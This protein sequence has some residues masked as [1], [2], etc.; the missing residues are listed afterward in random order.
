MATPTSSLKLSDAT[1][2]VLV[3]VIKAGNYAVTACNLAGIPEQTFYAWLQQADKDELVGATSQESLYIR[4]KESIKNAEADA[5]VSLVDMVTGVA[6]KD[7]NWI[8][9]MTLLERRHPDRWGR[10]DR[11]RIDINETKTVTIT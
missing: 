1:I 6:L 5:E 8:A 2:N 7:R 11:T 4:L 10:K 9:G 3:S